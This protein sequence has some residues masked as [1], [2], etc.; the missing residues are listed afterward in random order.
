[1]RSKSARR[2]ARRLNAFVENVDRKTLYERD[3]GV[4]GICKGPVSYEQMTIDHIVP[5][6]R[7][8][9]HSYANTQP[10]HEECNLAK[11]EMMP[12]EYAPSRSSKQRQPYLNQPALAHS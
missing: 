12:D 5:L 7:G 2:R 3:K 8:G 10:A 4:C 9:L 11:G 6:A 1:M